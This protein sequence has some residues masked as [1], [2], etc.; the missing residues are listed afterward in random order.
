MEDFMLRE[1]HNTSFKKKLKED[2]PT[3]SEERYGNNPQKIRM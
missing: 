3:E 1:F 2:N